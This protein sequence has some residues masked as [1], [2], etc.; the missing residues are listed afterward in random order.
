MI[1][2]WTKQANS[3]LLQ[4]VGYIE[5]EFGKKTK[6]KF[7]AN[8]RRVHT[9][10]KISPYMGRIEPLLQNRQST[11]RSIMVGRINRIIYRILDNTIEIADLWD[12]RRKPENLA[13]RI[14]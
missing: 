3:V 1:V 8:I 7:L 4:T 13:N 9:L 2:Q 14:S 10:L 5:K 12:M 11:Y 6:Q